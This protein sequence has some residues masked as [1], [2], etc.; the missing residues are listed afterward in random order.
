MKGQNDIVPSY[1]EAM[2]HSPIPVDPNQSGSISSVQPS[3]YMSPMPSAP[4][5]QASQQFVHR[6]CQ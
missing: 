6:K 1:E 5:P 3:M 4:P 2:Q